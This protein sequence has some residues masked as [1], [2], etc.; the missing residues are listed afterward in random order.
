MTTATETLA[1]HSIYCVAHA[2]GC[3]VQN[4][5]TYTLGDRPTARVANND[6]AMYLESGAVS[7]LCAD[8]MPDPVEVPLTARSILE[9]L[10]YLT[11]GVR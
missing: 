9:G 10:P 2:V 3:A 11:G 6:A 5:V 1:A 4:Y 8:G 7:C